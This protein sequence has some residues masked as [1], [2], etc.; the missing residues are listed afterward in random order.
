MVEYI[1]YLSNDR[2][3]FEDMC[4]SVICASAICM[5]PDRIC[6]KFSTWEYQ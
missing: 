5:W 3:D 6:A 2:L 1:K 4:L